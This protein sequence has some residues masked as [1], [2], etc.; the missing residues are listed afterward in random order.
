[1]LRHIVSNELFTTLIVFGLLIVATAKLLSPKRFNDFILIL[2][3]Y[4]YLK[5]YSRDQKFFDKFDGLLFINL[6]VSTSIFGFIIYEHI[7]GNKIASASSISRL[8]FTIGTFILIKILIERLIGSLF[9]IDSLI[10]QY[11]FQKTSY[12]NY[13]GILLLP[14]N[15]LLLFSFQPT[16]T[17]IYII[18][19]LLLIINVIGLITSYKTHQNIIKVNFS[20]FILYLCTLEIAPYIILY[21]VFITK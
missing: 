5:I 21:K 18:T 7:T 8:S 16:L 15:A 4:N 20:Y 14:I 9:Q 2:G 13:L 12:K 19:A 1:M 6:I 10:D 17:I 3:N 11:L